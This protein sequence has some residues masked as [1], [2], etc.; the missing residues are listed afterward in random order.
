[1]AEL[2]SELD[3]GIYF[4]WAKLENESMVYPMVMSVG[5]N[6]F[7]HN[8]KKSAVLLLGMCFYCGGLT[9]VPALLGSAY[10]KLFCAGFLWRNVKNCGS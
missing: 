4:G 6:P 7:Y 10:F 3:T 9:F 5:W 8:E 1:M 2:T